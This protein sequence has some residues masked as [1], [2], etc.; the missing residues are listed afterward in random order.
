[1]PAPAPD[2]RFGRF[3]LR[4]ATRELLDGQTRLRLGT[5]AFDLLLA[6]AQARGEVVSRETLFERAW[7]G[8]VVLDDNLKV[9]IMALR[10]L[11]G[12]HAIA[13]VPGRGY[14]FTERLQDDPAAH[15]PPPATS[16]LASRGEARSSTLPAHLPPLF[17]R[18]E[19]LTAAAS[20]LRRHAVVTIAGA[21]GIGKTSLALH[22]AQ[23][24]RGEFADGAWLIELAAIS[25]PGQ[26]APLVARSLG[27]VAQDEAV[28]VATIAAALR[29]QSMLLVLDN[30]EHVLDE[31][32]SLVDAL[33]RAAPNVRVVAT[34]QEVLKL[35]TE[36]VLRLA[37]LAVVDADPE[38]AA[39]SGA[40]QLFVA[41]AQAAD[42]GFALTKDNLA[43]VVEICRRLDGLPL[44]IELA[45]VRLPLLG[46]E[47]IRARLNERFRVLTGGA[48]FRPHRQQTLLAAFEW[49]HDLLTGPEQ[50]VFRRL[51]VFAGGFSL[52]LA[53]D[54]A[55]D[56]PIDAWAVLDHL[57]VL[58]DKSLVI[59]EGRDAPRYRLLESGRAFALEQLDRAGESAALLRR[60]A[61][62][63]RALMQ[64]FDAAV[65]REPRFDALVRRIEPELDNL[66]GALQWATG[67]SGDRETAIALCA[68]SDWLWNELAQPREGWHWCRLVRPWIDASTPPALAAR[69]WLAA[70]GLGRTALQPA[71]EWVDDL[72]HAAAGFRALGDTVGLYRALCLLGGQSDGL[73]SHREARDCLDEA[74]RIEDASWSPRLRLRRQASLEWWLDLDGQLEQARA[75]GRRHVALAAKSGG[76]AEVGALSNLA[77]TELALGNVEEAIALCRASIARAAELGRP[78][79]ALHT[80]ENL[81]PALLARGELDAAAQAI[82]SGRAASVRGIG[83]AFV[84]LI[85]AAALS[86][87][88]GDARLAAQLIGC[89]D[90]TYARD[91]RIMHPPERRVRERLLEQLRS[92]L[93]EHELVELQREG[94]T[95]SEDEAFARMPGT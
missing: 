72:R 31:V 68:S 34:S 29:S 81:V 69:F 65:A 32:V 1:M 86:H 36:Q 41:R 89:T 35:G 87:L 64:A 70:A 83:T 59:T 10:K 82:R 88:R 43:A 94:A 16:E 3:T 57:G 53:Q 22:L 60:H 20:L 44:A 93:A 49:S 62:A 2:L 63:L 14:R 33:T 66:Y 19:D 47:G 30:C 67:V 48:R 24:V 18:A 27:I 26:V 8:L 45:A 25:D 52:E 40:V 77:D 85:H 76:V 39:Q 28:A 74:E 56:D 46:L 95:W 50:T 51:G 11:L 5:R 13:T 37:P 80:Y 55:A 23:Q 92:V 6:L 90:R 73:I 79:A 17:G 91:G 9:Q 7:P 58:V 61:Q 15:A 42:R 21:A 75:A 71:R 54:V 12:A 78:A 38:A 84:L 4:P